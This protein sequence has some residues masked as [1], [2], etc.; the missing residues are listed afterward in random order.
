LILLVVPRHRLLIKFVKLIQ[1]VKHYLPNIQSVILGVANLPRCEIELH[2]VRH[3]LALESILTHRMVVKFENIISIFG[4][5][6]VDLT[7]RGLRLIEQ[8]TIRHRAHTYRAFPSHH[9]DLRV[10][11]RNQH[12]HLLKIRFSEIHFNHILRMD[13]VSWKQV[14]VNEFAGF[15]LVTW[16]LYLILS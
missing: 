15:V 16:W 13:L 7:V 8:F 12:I 11:R 6:V 3:L 2:I 5:A 9:T 10:S 14:R 4:I 1:P